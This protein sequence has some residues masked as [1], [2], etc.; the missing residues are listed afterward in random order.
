MFTTPILLISWKR[1]EKTRKVLNAIREVQPNKLYLACD[2]A[3]YKDKI[4]YSKVQMTRAI[5]DNN[6]D[7]NCEVKKLYSNKNNGCKLGVSKAIEWFFNN[8]KEGIILEDDCLPHNDFFYFCKDMLEK[9]RFDE[10]IWCISAHNL[11]KGEIHGEG[12]Y[13]FSRYSHCWGWATWKRC[14]DQYDPNI[15]KWPYLKKIKL[16]KQILDNKKQIKY[17][18]KIFDDL[19]YK[20]YPDTWDY[21]WTF[22][23]LINSGLTII[24]NINLISNIGFDEEATHTLIGNPDTNN[25]ELSQKQSG[26]FPIIEPKLIVRSKSA[27]LNVEYVCYS[28]Y[29]LYSPKWAINKLKKILKKIKSSLKLIE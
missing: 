17:W 11:Q 20:S 24:P 2:G 1:P 26:L 23:C 13:Y 10:R 21:Q 22:T 18:T 15:K 5:L 7:W 27:D 28:G 14:W 25:I 8:E 19:F 3:N 6:I 4:I 9:Y 16:L 29:P 12:S